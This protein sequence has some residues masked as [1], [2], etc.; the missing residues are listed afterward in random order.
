MRWHFPSAWHGE[1]A[2]LKEHRKGCSRVGTQA[3]RHMR[4]GPAGRGK[5]I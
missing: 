1:A 5:S 4:V 3:L 2:V